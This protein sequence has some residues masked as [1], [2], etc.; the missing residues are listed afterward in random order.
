MGIISLQ[1]NGIDVFLEHGHYL[2]QKGGVSM[3]CDFG[4]LKQCIPEFEEC[5]EE[6]AQERQL[7]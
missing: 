1:I 3:R 4:E 5:T 6:I 7:A 2:L